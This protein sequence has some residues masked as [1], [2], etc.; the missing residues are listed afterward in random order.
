MQWPVGVRYPIVR[1]SSAPHNTQLTANGSGHTHT[2][3]RGLRTAYC[4]IIGTRSEGAGKPAGALV[5]LGMYICSSNGPDVLDYYG[6]VLCLA[7][8]L[9]QYIKVLCFMTEHHCSSM[10]L[11]AMSLVLTLCIACM[12]ASW[13]VTRSTRNIYFFTAYIFFSVMGL[14]MFVQVMDLRSWC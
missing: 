9:H 10:F 5:I 6:V 7:P 1:S 8:A 13:L 4:Q 14:C 3:Y 11:F 2:V 12:V